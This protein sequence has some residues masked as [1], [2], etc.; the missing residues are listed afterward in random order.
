MVENI[1]QA[2]IFCAGKGTRLQAY[3]GD[4]PKVLIE[5]NGKTLLEYKLEML[6]GLV[7]EVILVVGYMA[8]KV[9]DLIGDSYGNL[10]ISYCYQRELLG[11]GHAL[12]QAK[13]MLD[14]KFLVLNGDDIYSR[15]DI[16]KLMDLPLAVM[17]KRVSNPESFGVFKLDLDNNYLK[18]IVEKPKEFISNIANIGVYVF[19][20]KI[21]DYELKKSIRGEYE[22]ID[23]LTYLILDGRN[24]VVN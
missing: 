6:D 20:S 5:V 4:I 9:R 2:V 8:D 23:Y 22:I 14:G 10:K 24:I 11:S 7:E 3:T 12:L 13:D 17:G 19:D 1:S 18:E 15:A 21:F 16:S